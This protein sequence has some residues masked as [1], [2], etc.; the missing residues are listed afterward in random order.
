MKTLRVHK[1][2]VMSCLASFAASAA[3]WTIYPTDRD[4]MTPSQQIT[5]AVTRAASGDTVVFEPGVYQLD[6]V[7]FM[8][9]TTASGVTSRYY[10]H[11]PSKRLD[12]VGNTSG[13]W[14]DAVVLKGNGND[15]FAYMESE[16]SSFRN[17]TFENFAAN[18]HP[19]TKVNNN[20]IDNIGL[21]GAIAFSI[22]NKIESTA[23]SNCVFRGNVARG[24]GAISRVWA[25]DCLFTNNAAYWGGGAVYSSRMT[26]CL[27]V[28]NKT[29]SGG[30]GGAVCWPNRLT[31]CTFI[32]N[33]SGDSAGAVT[34]DGSMI[35]ED[36][37]FRDNSAGSDGGA[38]TLRQKTTVSRCVFAGNSASWKG[39]AVYSRD[40]SDVNGGAGSVFADCLFTNNISRSK[41]AGIGGA[42]YAGVPDS[43]GPVWFR[44]CTFAS[45]CA[46]TECFATYGGAYSNCTFFG[47]LATN[48]TCGVVGGPSD[49][50]V[51]VVD[52]V[53]SNNY[54]FSG[55]LVRYAYCTN[56]LFCGNEVPRNGG[57][58]NRSRA[59]D[60]RFVGNRKWDSFCG[61]ASNGGTGGT[62]AANSPS[63][64]A[65]ESTLVKCDLDLGCIVNSV[66]VDCY[67]HTLTNKGAH[68]VFYGH[69]VATNC[70]IADCTPPD[71]RAIVYRWGSIDAAYVTG[72]DY[73]NCTFAGNVVNRML[74]HQQEYGIYTPF[75]N[76]LFYNNRDPWKNLIDAVYKVK[77]SSRGDL[78]NLDSGMAMSNSVY[79]IVGTQTAGDTWH[80]LGG[81]KVIAPND[82][83]VAGEK[84]AK[85]GVHKYALRP[86]SPAIG[87]GDARMFS[88]TDLDY[89]G[90]LRL[91]DGRLDAGCFECWLNPM[92]TVIVVY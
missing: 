41:S 2:F 90:N 61:M 64:D 91:R 72:S 21:G 32:G 77:D 16:G 84:A 47:N 15:R 82:L 24:G 20:N 8:N 80:D 81:N 63:G 71:P 78:S 54:S 55:G 74:Y 86:G 79:G 59:I 29:F 68:C 46:F 69:N 43:Q 25:T 1:V 87:V 52:C 12:F 31:E 4:G 22:Y 85:L 37:T 13:A 23:V 75:K 53:F 66:L 48:G 30:I 27:C 58:V 73:V 34:G 50:L 56:T 6:G 17:I 36:C 39:G 28:N 35:V 5:N 67:I 3:T 26:R 70:L 9:T 57:V 60:C 18:D 88:N 49:R 65:T 33:V 76:C 44:S 10:V 40:Q 11:L 42:V 51:S 45:N 38:M 62:P 14:N 83:K 89:S 92:G 19:E 7:S